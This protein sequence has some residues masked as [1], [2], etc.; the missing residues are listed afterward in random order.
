MSSDQ[1][2]QD[3]RSPVAE[4][5]DLVDSQDYLR[6]RI[7]YAAVD[8]GL[9][10]TLEDT[11]KSSDA[12]AS[13]LDLDPSYTYRLL[14]ALTS[15]GVVTE[16]DQ[17]GFALTPVG[18]CFQSDHPESI[19][20][21]IEFS[22]HPD[23]EAAWRHLPAM[24][25]EGGPD[26]YVREFGHDFFT[27]IEDA[28]ELA[29]AFNEL[30]TLNSKREAP[31]VLDAVSELDFSGMRTL[32]DVGGGHGYLLARLLDA[33][34]KLEGIVLDLPSVV[35]EHDQH[36]ASEIGVADRCE[37]MAG[38][39]FESV[40]ESDAYVLKHILHDWDDADCETILTTIHETAPADARLFVAEPLVPGPGVDHPSKQ[41]DIVMLVE[42]GAR[43]RT[44]TEYEAL[45]ERTGWELEDVHASD[46]G[47][48]SVIEA[49]KG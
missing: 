44:R 7:L 45:F 32:C 34:P 15:Y 28:P 14:R 35:E 13:T 30:Q 25:R 29:A 33:Y 17:R 12:M 1:S 5:M 22:F 6:Q 31:Q 36:W 40:P 46:E 24:V 38:D 19:A 26:G 41:Y 2:S 23:H 10:D 39:M 16:N 3:D 4:A 9:F 11:H 49:T 20:G 43:E 21:V 8:L 47:P 37:Y 48:L 42:N 18:V 27:H